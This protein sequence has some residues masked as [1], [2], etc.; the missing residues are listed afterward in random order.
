CL[1]RIMAPNPPKTRAATSQAKASSNAGEGSSSNPPQEGPPRS[2]ED[3]SERESHA[4]ALQEARTQKA[5]DYSMPAHPSSS[6]VDPNHQQ[7][8]TA[9]VPTLAEL[10]DVDMDVCPDEPID[11]VLRFQELLTAKQS[12]VGRVSSILA[13]RLLRTQKVFDTQPPDAQASLVSQRTAIV[14][15]LE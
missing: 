2:S 6:P 15:P 11:P 5:V 13:D 14:A 1:T 8:S 12:E 10:M 4:Q 3:P 7:A 9:P